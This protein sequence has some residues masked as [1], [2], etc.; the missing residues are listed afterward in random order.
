MS[1]GVTRGGVTVKVLTGRSAAD[2]LTYRDKVDEGQESHV[3]DATRHCSHDVGTQIGEWQDVRVAHGTDGK[4]KT[5]RAT[6]E[7]VDPETGLHA[8]GQRGTHVRYW[9]GKSNRWRKR[10]AP[11]GL[12]VR[13]A[14]GIGYFLDRADPKGAV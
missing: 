1:A 5:T 11:A 3:F 14:R 7:T 4:M 2:L 6:Y 13:T 10:L 8:N 9:D 12:T